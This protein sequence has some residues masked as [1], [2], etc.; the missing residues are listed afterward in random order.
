VGEYRKKIKGELR[1]RYVV[2][3]PLQKPRVQT[4]GSG[5]ENHGWVP[6]DGCSALPKGASL[7]VERKVCPV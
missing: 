5:G 6:S 4:L 3:V 1:P 2:P 7:I